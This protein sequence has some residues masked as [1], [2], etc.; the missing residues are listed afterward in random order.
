MSELQTSI[1]EKVK[2]EL[3][4]TE[5]IDAF[6]L[7]DILYKSR[8]L[9]HPDLVE[10]KL[11][12]DANERFKRLNGLLTELKVYLDSLKLSKSPKELVVYEKNYQSI[13][14]KSLIVQLEEK[15]KG[16]KASLSLKEHEIERLKKII[17]KA[18]EDK[19]EELNTQL[20]DLYEPKNSNF[21]V[22]GI[23]TFLLLFINIISQ[24]TSLKESI[25]DLIPFNIIY[26]NYFL[27]GL[28][29][30]IGLKLYYKNWKLKKLQNFAE[31]LKSSKTIS[32]FFSYN[33]KEHDD[34][35]K[36]KYFLESDLENFINSRFSKQKYRGYD[37][38]Y[39]GKKSL[40]KFH[41]K[42][43]IGDFKSLFTINDQKSLN[44]LRDIFIY[45][46]LTKGYIKFGKTDNLD[47]EFIV[48]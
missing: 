12:E 31:I 43:L 13:I 37:Y 8:N 47:R 39:R 1:I 15:N 32:D 46:L 44:Y 40:Y 30:I 9:S 28:L 3:K 6:G 42:K 11:Q 22:L 19:S 17:T 18:Q 26:L 35:F 23:S 10:P 4:I 16:L 7:Y 33:G 38:R 36:R 45:N 2:S 29:I 21:I 14:D 5:E 48:E 41:S 24:I 27:F 34:Y 20:K 25:V